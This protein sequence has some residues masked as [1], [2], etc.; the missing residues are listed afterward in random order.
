MMDNYS[1]SELYALQWAYDI[2]L[3]DDRIDTA[4][5][6]EPARIIDIVTLLARFAAAADIDCI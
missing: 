1:M 4:E 6:T 3:L 2:G 5:P